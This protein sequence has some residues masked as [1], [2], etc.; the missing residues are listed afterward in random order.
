MFVERCIDS[1]AVGGT[2]ALVTPHGWLYLD[3]YEPLR[4]AA[5]ESHSWCFAARLGTH[6]FE[7]ISGEVVNVRLVSQ[8][9]AKPNS[10]TSLLGVDVSAEKSPSGK[11]VQLT[12]E[13]AISHNQFRQLSNPDARLIVGRES[14]REDSAV[15]LSKLA[16]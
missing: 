2:T 15:L 7:T 11:A 12:L 9:K 5:L 4:R 10:R 13:S 6:A 1:C 14:A 3:R 16:D 8:T